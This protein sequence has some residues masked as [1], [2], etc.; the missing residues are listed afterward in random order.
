M[1][2]DVAQIA[3]IDPAA[4]GWAPDEVFGL[5]PWRIADALTQILAAR[6]IPLAKLLNHNPVALDFVQIK[7]DHRGRLG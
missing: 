5:L 7:L 4:A 6:D 1:I 2:K 3:A